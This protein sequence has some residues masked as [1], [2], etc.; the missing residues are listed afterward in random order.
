VL[1]A[2]PVKR[3]T[4][5]WY[6]LYTLVWGC[7]AGIYMIFFSDGA[8]NLGFTSLGLL[9]WLGLLI[10]PI[11]WRGSDATGPWYLDY[12]LRFQA[13]VTV[14]AFAG[15]FRSEYFYQM[16][17]ME[18]GF[19]TT[20]NL[21]HVPFFTYLLTVVYFTTYFTLINCGIRL[22]R[23]YLTGGG[24]WAM[25]AVTV[26]VCFAVAFLESALNANPFISNLFCYQSLAWQLTWGSL[27]YGLWFV[28]GA[29]FWFPI[30]EDPAVG[31]MSWGQ[32]M[33]R[34]LASWVLVEVA[35]EA[36]RIVLGD[37]LHMLPYYRPGYIGLSSDPNF[38]HVHSCLVS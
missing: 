32:V 23:S 3:R 25:A 14:W 21:N 38:D 27:F 12:H 8:G 1:A 18:Y 22:A 35:C 33:L 13:F 19:P 6:L 29:P 28:I 5:L 17:G 24:K 10:P 11:I 30:D 34:A 4:E 9:L 20:W 7:V 26:G 36:I 37:W 16:T 31:H 2:D 15:G